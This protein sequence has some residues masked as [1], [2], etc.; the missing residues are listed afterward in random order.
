MA[1][2]YFSTKYKK[3][4]LDF[5]GEQWAEFET[6]KFVQKIRKNANHAVDVI[7][8]FYTCLHLTNINR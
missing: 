2:K 5:G 8:T 7:Q 1:Y 6:R 3:H 4:I